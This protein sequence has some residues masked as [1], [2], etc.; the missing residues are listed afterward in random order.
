MDY[1]HFSKI[2]LWSGNPR[3]NEV[4]VPRL[5]EL[6]KLHGQKTRIGIWVKN[7][8]IYKGNTTY[9][10]LVRLIREW[11]QCLPGESREL[12]DQ[13]KKGLLKIEWMQFPS[14][15]AAIA[16]AI[17]DN[18]SSEWAEWDDEILSSLLK[19]ENVK[20]TGFT[21]KEAGMLHFLPDPVTMNK[22]RAMKDKGLKGRI[23]VILVDIAKRDLVKSLIVK[24]LNVSHIDAEVQ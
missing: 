16:Y 13:L 1:I 10:A 5:M 22:L 21:K 7:S 24:Y 19:I 3:R 12:F 6:L 2:K 18:R 15:Q 11:K 8:T 17:A 23:V 4:A 14:E 20:G 9:K